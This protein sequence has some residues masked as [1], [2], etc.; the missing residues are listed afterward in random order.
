MATTIDQRIQRLVCKICH[1]ARRI[2]W[3]SPIFDIIKSAQV[4]AQK[5][6][7]WAKNDNNFNVACWVLQI[8]KIG[9]RQKLH[10]LK[11]HIVYTKR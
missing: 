2:F 6:R 11:L 5:P 4:V 7:F 1:F 3:L 10:C 9:D 8:S